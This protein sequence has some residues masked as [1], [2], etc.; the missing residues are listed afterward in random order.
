VGPQLSRK[1]APNETTSR[2]ASKSSRGQATPYACRV[3]LI[4]ASGASASKLTC[5]GMP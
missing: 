5:A 4:A 3:A 2:A 1:S